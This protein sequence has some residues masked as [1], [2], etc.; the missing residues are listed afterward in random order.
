MSV[1]F[2]GFGKADFTGNNG[3]GAISIPGLKV[4][5]VVI[6]SVVGSTTQS[7]GSVFERIVSVSDEL[8]QIE[9]SNLSTQSCYIVFVRGV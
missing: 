8:Q 2:A 6:T 3:S 7:P 4:G 5:D 9:N 1:N